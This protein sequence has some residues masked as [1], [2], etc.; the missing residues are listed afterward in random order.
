MVWSPE[1]VKE[2][3][4]VREMET[5]SVMMVGI[6]KWTSKVEMCRSTTYWKETENVPC[7]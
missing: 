5:A 1:G 2:R 7:I 6:K 4:L 3:G